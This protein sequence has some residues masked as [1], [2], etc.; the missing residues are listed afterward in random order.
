MPLLDTVS[1]TTRQSSTANTDATALTVK[2]GKIMFE[3]QPTAQV[4]TLATFVSD[5]S[6]A[7]TRRKVGRGWALFAGFYL[8]LAC[9]P[10]KR[11]RANIHP[12]CSASIISA[13][14]HFH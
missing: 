14:I 9:E 8:G 13:P 2:G 3:V 4:E 10:K 1:V 6:P 7:V 12:A 5:G 11:P